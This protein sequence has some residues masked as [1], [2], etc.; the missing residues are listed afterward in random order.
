MKLFSDKEYPSTLLAVLIVLG[1]LLSPPALAQQYI[2]INHYQEI[3]AK[4]EQ[5][6][7]TIDEVI[8]KLSIVKGL[9][10]KE[11]YYDSAVGKRGSVLVWRSEADWEAYLKS[12]LRKALVNKLRPLLQ[13]T[14]K[15][16]GYP[17]YRPNN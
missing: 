14:V 11:F 15:S 6:S 1:A 17:V 5:L 13:G 7:E 2:V 9:I 4:S 3:P 16:N 8:K 12:D 10:W